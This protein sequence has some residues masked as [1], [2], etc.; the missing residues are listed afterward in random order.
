MINWP[1]LYIK[2]LKEIYMSKL[3]SLVCPTHKRPTLQKRFADSVFDTCYKKSIVEIIFAIDEDDLVARETAK[4]IQQK[5]GEDSV[6]IALVN[7]D[8]ERL[9]EIVNECVEVCPPRGGVIGN[10]AD[11]TVFRSK[12]WDVTVLREFEKYE[13][14]ILLLWGDDGLWGGSLA[15]HFFLHKNW[16]KTLG[17][18]QPTHFYADWTDHWMMRLAKRL[19]RAKVIKD[20]SKLFIEHLHAEHGGMEKDETYFLVKERR[21]K[22]VAQGINFSHD[23]APKRLEQF[24]EEEYIKLKYFID[25]YGKK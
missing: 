12:R 9:A 11:D 7:P 18:M 24:H 5:H 21:E 19:G 14:K 22:N 8:L 17:H 6:R 13:D 4:E 20:R 15:S 3:I 1:I 10:L 25:N 23:N 16:I 2:Q